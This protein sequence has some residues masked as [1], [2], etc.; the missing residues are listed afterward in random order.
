MQMCETFERLDF[1][2]TKYSMC[3]CENRDAKTGIHTEMWLLLFELEKPLF[4]KYG[5]TLFANGD[6]ETFHDVYM[7]TIEETIAAFDAERG[8]RFSSYFSYILKKRLLDACRKNQRVG[9]NNISLQ[10]YIEINGD[11][12][13]D[14]ASENAFTQ[15]ETDE[16]TEMLLLQLTA[17]IFSLR[18]KLPQTQRGNNLQRYY[19][20]FH[21]SRLVG[22]IKK[23]YGRWDE[24]LCSGFTKHEDELIESLDVGLLDFTYVCAVRS[25][26]E[27]AVTHLKTYGEIPN[28][29]GKSPRDKPIDVPYT[30]FILAAYWLFA[31]G[32]QRSNVLFSKMEKKYD[33]FIRSVFGEQTQE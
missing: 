28:L 32:E 14:F 21:T 16:K 12:F 8:V 9:Q 3:S 29:Q 15:Y 5:K 6:S 19:V 7:D 31:Y 11:T 13:A 27:I 24:A 10:A 26:A 2:A 17:L 25:I 22:F 4:R 18:D 23:N 20:L 1:L 30:Q 33:A